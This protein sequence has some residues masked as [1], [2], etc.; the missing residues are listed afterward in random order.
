M[1]DPSNVPAVPAPADPLARHRLDLEARE[2]GKWVEIRGDRWLVASYSAKAVATER[3]AAL[4]E[5]GLPQNGD[6]PPQHVDRVGAH[7]F[8]RAILRGC[9]L[10]DAPE[11]AYTP[12]LGERIFRDPE[13]AELRDELQKAALGDFTKAETAKAAVLGNS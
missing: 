13:L 9:K 12:E 10:K 2:R 6:V 4:S 7:I 11:L 3:A 5:L 1:P 8:A